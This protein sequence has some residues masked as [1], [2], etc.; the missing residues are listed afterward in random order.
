MPDSVVGR[1]SGS[2]PTLTPQASSSIEKEGGKGRGRDEDKDEEV[3]ARELYK[4]IK[5]QV[6][7]KFGGNRGSLKGFLV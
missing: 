3:V 4:D 2:K 1:S 7:N 6:S 5:I